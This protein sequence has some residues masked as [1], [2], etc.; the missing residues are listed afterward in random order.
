MIK[1]Y[2]IVA[3][4]NL[5]RNRVFSI[6]NIVGLAI[7]LSICALIYQYIQFELSYDKFNPKAD[8][9]YRVTLAN[10]DADASRHASATNHPAVA[11]AMKSDFPE[12]ETFSRLAR[13]NFFVTSLTLSTQDKKGTV[14]SSMKKKCF[15]P[16]VLSS[17]CFLIRWPRAMRQRRLPC[18]ILLLS[19]KAPPGNSLEMNRPSENY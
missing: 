5:V 12:I 2:L 17:P 13:T 8:R 11:P 19:P 14:L 1:N 4:R 6:I 15:W 18:L 16:M 9:L 7:G 3:W 10:T